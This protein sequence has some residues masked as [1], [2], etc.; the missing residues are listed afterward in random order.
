MDGSTK[1][2]PDKEDI[3]GVVQDSNDNIVV[4]F[5]ASIGIRDS[6]KAEFLALVF[7]LE[8]SPERE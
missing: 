7:T 6:N 2:K 1:G 8:V 4:K 3:V 5:A